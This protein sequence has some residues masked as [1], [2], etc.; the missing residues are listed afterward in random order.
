MIEHRAYARIGLLGNPSDVYYGK[1]MSF[2]LANF[3][4]T[5]TLRSSDDLIIQPHP[6]HDLVHFASL[7][8]LVFSFFFS[9]HHHHNHHDHGTKK[10][11][12][13]CRSIG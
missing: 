13:T 1:T 8:H 5:V 10:Y 7:P 2:S 9:M 11:L 12:I 4:A 6:F 3:Y